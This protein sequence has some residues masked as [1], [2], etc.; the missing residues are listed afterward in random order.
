[1]ISDAEQ[2]QISRCGNFWEKTNLRSKKQKTT[3]FQK[4]R[5]ILKRPKHPS[6]GIPVILDFE[7]NQK[8]KTI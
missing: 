6:K 5:L 1:M 4:M 7:K 3:K 8:E 2:N